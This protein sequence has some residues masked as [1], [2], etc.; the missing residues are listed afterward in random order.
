[1]LLTTLYNIVI[2]VL[3]KYWSKITAMRI[4]STML[5]VLIALLLSPFSLYSQSSNSG[6]IKTVD[7]VQQFDSFGRLIYENGRSVTYDHSEQLFNVKETEG[8]V[9][10]DKALR[11]PDNSESICDPAWFQATMGSCIGLRSMN[12]ADFNN[13]G[14]TEIICSAGSGFGSGKYWYFLEYNEQNGEYEISW[15]SG[16]KDDYS[17]Y[18]STIEYFDL[19]SNGSYEIL[20]GYR[21]GK[22]D[23]YDAESRVLL[24]SFETGAD[25]LNCIKYGDADN[26]GV[27]EII[28]CDDDNSY[29]VNESTFDLE[30]TIEF[31]GSD[32]DIGDVDA[33]EYIELIYTN[34]DVIL[35]NGTTITNKWDFNP[36]SEYGQLELSDIDADDMLEIVYTPGWYK[37]KIF[38]ADLQELKGEIDSDLDVDA[39]LLADVNGDGVD[40]LLYGDGQWGNIYCHDANTTALMWD[41]DNPEHGTTEINVADVDNDG[42]LEVM[43]GAGCS[44][45]GS[46]HIF[47]HEIPSGNFEYQSKHIDPPFYSVEIGDV[48]DDGEAEIVT[49]SSASNSGYDS[50]IMTIFNAEDHSIEWQC[51]EQYFEN[52]WE[53]MYAMEIEDIDGDGGT[54]IIVAAGR[55]YT[56]KIWIIN[57]Q[58]YEIESSYIFNVEDF[59]EFYSLD[60]ADVDGDGVMECIVGEEWNV[61][62][63]DPNDFSVE[64]SIELP[65]YNR[66]RT[67]HAGNVDSGPE[68]EIVVCAG[69]IYVIDGTT[70]EEW[71]TEGENYTNCD[72]VDIDEDGVPEIIACTSSG[73][74]VSIDGET[75]QITELVNIGVEIDGVRMADITLDGQYEYIFTTEGSV[76]FRT[77][78]GLELQTQA[79]GTHAGSYDALKVEDPLQNGSFLIFAGTNYLVVELTEHCYQ[80]LDFGIQ[81]TGDEASCDPGNDGT[82][83]VI[84]TGGEGPYTYLWDF[85]GTNAIETG[86][87][88]GTYVVTVTDQQGC[89][90]T[91]EVS[92]GQAEIST[93]LRAVMVG[94]SGVDD[95]MA[96]IVIY[97]GTSPFSILWSTGATSQQIQNLAPGDYSVQI[98]DAK[99]CTDYYEFIIE[100]DTIIYSLNK[101]DVSCYGYANGYA[102]VIIESG[103]MPFTIEWSDGYIGWQNS[104]MEAGEYSVSITDSLGCFVT[105]DFTI[106]EPEGMTLS[107]N[108][109]P[110]NPDTP[111]GEGTATVN[112][113]GGVPPYYFQWNDPYYQTNQTAINLVSGEYGV[114]VRDA[115][116]CSLSE[117]GFVTYVNGVTQHQ[118]KEMI[119][120]YPNPSKSVV[121]IDCRS[122]L[123]E[124]LTIRLFS[125]MGVQERIMKLN[126]VSEDII[127]MD[128]AN[129]SPGIYIMQI[130]TLETSAV[131]K[132]TV[133]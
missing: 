103:V 121:N 117:A 34:G 1:M 27:N 86:M 2:F 72:L 106:I 50:G 122:L 94:C 35:L 120:V 60:V 20:C 76:Y 6:R 7:D 96:E 93:E 67:I 114:A 71:H 10:S 130:M 110:D 40:E 47:I 73:L 54:E 90:K 83:E 59:D 131:W 108:T 102:Y 42:Q 89:V 101:F 43:W 97:Q 24:T 63:I 26:D 91:G 33:D 104:N 128:I 70:H 132:V 107:I 65:G 116:N 100:Q 13:D 38:D 115:N 17:E 36:D 119:K 80:C 79:Y 125:Q 45:T 69:Y 74:I 57:G 22:V 16:W 37:I 81:L 133:K 109:T 58:T 87:E 15:V 21:N 95:G 9:P 5:V 111:E 118:I 113:I 88:P 30:L 39:L 32:M 92:V 61:H 98:T 105:E 46:D 126:T 77:Q 99:N 44:S 85:G 19:E 127:K 48:D 14:K 56:G 66:P 25:W 75:Q 8:E 12:S 11:N 68:Q 18:I 78:S 28:C 64:W 84:A 49:L 112:V 51:D 3:R 52:V 62:I 41:I 82:V 31:G 55:T 29:I 23:I 53:G 4:R 123:D 129:L 124:D